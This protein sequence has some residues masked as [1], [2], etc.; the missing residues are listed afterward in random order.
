LVSHNRQ[1][2]ICWNGRNRLVGAPLLRGRGG[3]RRD[4]QQQSTE[5]GSIASRLHKQR[6]LVIELYR[7]HERLSRKTQAAGF[8][9]RAF[10]LLGPRAIHEITRTARRSSASCISWIVLPDE[11]RRPKRKRVDTQSTL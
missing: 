2:T 4:H 10:L 8:S 9:F 7:V 1:K 3:E 6:R 11:S 5:G